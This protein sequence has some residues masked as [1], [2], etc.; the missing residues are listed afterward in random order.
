MNAQTQENSAQHGDDGHDVHFQP[1]APGNAVL[2]HLYWPAVKDYKITRL[3]E[4]RPSI[5]KY[6]CSPVYKEK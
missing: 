6:D 2:H 1:I 4:K 5:K 3:Q